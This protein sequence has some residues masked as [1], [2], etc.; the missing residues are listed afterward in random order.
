MPNATSFDPA[1]GNPIVVGGTTLNAVVPASLPPG[2]YQVRIFG[3]TTT[4]QP[5]GRASDAVTLFVN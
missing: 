4:G 5:L 3:L 2:G 1:A